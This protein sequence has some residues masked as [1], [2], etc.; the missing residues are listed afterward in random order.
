MIGDG[1]HLGGIQLL[2]EDQ[3]IGVALEGGEHDVSQFALTDDQ[4]GIDPVA[5]LD[6][7]FHHFHI[8][9]THQLDKFI[10]RFLGLGLG[11]GGNAD[12]NGPVPAL[13]AF[14]GSRGAGKFILQG[15]NEFEKIR[16]LPGGHNRRQKM[17]VFAV[18]RHGN[19]MHGINFLRQAAVHDLDYCHQIQ[20]EKKQIHQVILGEIFPGQMGMD[21]AQSLQ[22]SAGGADLGESGDDDFFIIAD[23]DRFH[24]AGAGKQQADLSADL[25]RQ[26]RHLPGHLRRD[27]QPRIGSP[28]GEP[29]QPFEL[30]GFQ[31]A[32]I[33][34]EIAYIVSPVLSDYCHK[35]YRMAPSTF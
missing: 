6:D 18:N 14:S 3:Q 35:G 12:Q 11:L 20:P 7:G 1:A 16:R 30:P 22:P 5:P 10:H 8:V 27:N 9:G 4:L 13:L 15:G 21:A 19:Q 24:L 2:I 34:C 25:R 33:S 17:P 29:F 26:F 28:L 23:N 31:A 32:E